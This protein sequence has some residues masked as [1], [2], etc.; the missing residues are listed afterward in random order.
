MTSLHTRHIQPLIL[1]GLDGNNWRL[2]DYVARGGSAWPR[3]CRFPNRF[4]VEL[5]ATSI[6]W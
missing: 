3:W 4:E 2:K 1:K 5:Y 6:P